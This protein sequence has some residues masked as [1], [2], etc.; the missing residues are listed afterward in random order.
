MIGTGRRTGPWWPH[1]S[2]FVPKAFGTSGKKVWQKNNME[3]YTNTVFEAWLGEILLYPTFKSE[4][5]KY[6]AISKASLI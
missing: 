5:G 4:L 2:G 3:I 6:L 1:S